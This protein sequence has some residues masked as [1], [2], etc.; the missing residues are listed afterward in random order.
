MAWR[1]LVIESVAIVLS[2]LLAFAIDA[3]WQEHQDRGRE[4]AVLRGLLRDYRSSRPE[5]AARLRLARRMAR[6]NALL[7]EILSAAAAGSTVSVPDSLIHAV[8]GGPTY[9][10]ATDALD[11]AVASGEIELIRSEAIRQELA[12]WRRALIDTSEDEREVR[13]ISDEQVEPLLAGSLDLGPYYAETL[14]WAIDERLVNPAGHGGVRAS[15][16][17]ASVLG[18]RGF[19]ARFS[20]E[21][22]AGLLESLDRIVGLLETELGTH[23]SVGER[24]GAR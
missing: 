20:A 3:W 12:A 5:L 18:L 11:A 13:R 6:N 15:P 8:I 23:G 19:Y 21:D 10:P 22:L 14:S 4:T 9:E 7:Q 24:G 16:E 1:R 2:I 17:L